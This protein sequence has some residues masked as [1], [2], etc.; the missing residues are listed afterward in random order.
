MQ[1]VRL[2]L[3][4]LGNM[5]TSHIN[6]Y[7]AGKNPKIEITAICDIDPNKLENG[8]K[9]LGKDVHS[10]LSADKLIES[11]D[12]DAVLIATPHYDH[13]TIA[14][15]AFNSGLHVLSEKP[16]G[17]YTK[18]VREANEVAGKSGKV[19]GIM[20]NQRTRPAFQKLRE[21]IKNGELGEMKRAV[22]IITDWYRT[23]A[24]YNSGGW[25]ATWGGEGGGVLLNQC[26][27]NIDLMQWVC[28]IPKRVR[29][30]AYY[31]KYHDIEVEDDVTSYYEY[32]NGATGLFITT[33]G[34]FPGTNRFEYTGD[35]GKVI[36]EGDKM[37]YVKIEQSVTDFTKNSTEGFGRMKTEVE[38]YEFSEGGA[39]PEIINNFADAILEGASLLS[40]GCEGINGLTISN[41]MHLSS[42]IDDWVEIPLDEDKFYEMLQE[43]IKNSTYV[44][45]DVVETV[46]DL[47]KTFG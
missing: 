20:Y 12:V 16:A 17:V 42:W 21:M 40:P 22:W 31:G 27:H 7:L 15:K 43:K 36:I 44:K 11:G 32:E 39:H 34:E 9:L 19:F 23:Q 28:G 25:R 2:G 1:K 35:K 24:Y 30:S 13:P 10:Y 29:A 37:T 41:A 5:G 45:K 38:V 18:A 46:S 6:N 33:T 14:I 4:G 26:P 8:K 47:S 3:I